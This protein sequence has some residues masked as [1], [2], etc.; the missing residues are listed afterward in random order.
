MNNFYAGS[1]SILDR[2]LIASIMILIKENVC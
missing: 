1:F 2:A